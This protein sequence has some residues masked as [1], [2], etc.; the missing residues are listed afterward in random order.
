MYMYY[1]II[2]SVHQA[3]SSKRLY[4]CTDETPVIF[5]ALHFVAVNGFEKSNCFRVSSNES[6]RLP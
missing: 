4:Q 1:M 5:L 6:Y 3:V 2:Y